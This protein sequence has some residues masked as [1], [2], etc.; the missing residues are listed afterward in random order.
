MKATPAYRK[1]LRLAWCPGC[2]KYHPVSV[3]RRALI[4]K[5]IRIGE[6]DPEVA[7]HLG[8]VCIEK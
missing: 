2:G 8:N 4:W 3:A 6:T 7:Y 5:W 1:P